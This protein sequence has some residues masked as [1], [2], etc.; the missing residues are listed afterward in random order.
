MQQASEKHATFSALCPASAPAQH[1][2]H[3]PART[4]S[5]VGT[6]DGGTTIVS[7]S[8]TGAGGYSAGHVSH[9]PGPV[10]MLP[11]PLHYSHHPQQPNSQL[12]RSS[13]MAQAC[14]D[15]ATPR[16]P[17]TAPALTASGAVTGGHP[18]TGHTL[19]PSS[20][21]YAGV[22]GRQSS[23]GL[24]S[25]TF[26]LP[27]LGSSTLGAQD[28]SG[29]SAAQ[30]SDGTATA[31]GC[32]L[33]TT[34][35]VGHDVG[36]GTLCFQMPTM[37]QLR[38]ASSM[39]VADSGC[40]AQ[41][42]W[43]GILYAAAAP[44]AAQ[45]GINGPSP[46]QRQEAAVRGAT[47]SRGVSGSGM[48]E[49]AGNALSPSAH[50]H[51]T[52]PVSSQP[53]SRRSSGVSR[54]ELGAE[55]QP[56]YCALTA[57]STIVSGHHDVGPAGAGG[58]GVQA[59]SVHRVQGPLGLPPAFPSK[60]S[61]AHLLAPGSYSLGKPAV[62]FR[63]APHAYTPRIKDEPSDQTF[64]QGSTLQVRTSS[65]DVGAFLQQR[66]SVA[67]PLMATAP[68][69]SADKECPAHAPGFTP[70]GQ[71]GAMPSHYAAPASHHQ[72]VMASV[73][74]HMES[75]V[76]WAAGKGHHSTEEVQVGHRQS[77][78]AGIFSARTSGRSQGGSLPGGGIASLRVRTSSAG[79]APVPAQY[80]S[81][82]DL[83]DLSQLLSTGGRDS[84]DPL[85]LLLPSLHIPSGLPQQPVPQDSNGLAEEN[86][87]GTDSASD[88]GMF[89]AGIFA[90]DC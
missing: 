13:S 59:G 52:S 7:A 23:S 60:A 88:R 77:S 82:G 39:A 80:H 50:V 44:G 54:Q 19:S 49:Q 16:Y 20:D 42:R 28:A 11:Q 21:Q 68:L 15:V 22:M 48:Q 30:L 78:D 75:Q 26:T 71:L 85:L 86:T 79:G 74:G 37:G 65:M 18:A 34:K 33:A 84:P 64:T 2:H 27:R 51:C 89:E 45:V 70:S 6:V 29:C 36:Q 67:G 12:I 31:L 41:A 3:E 46:A 1:P 62:A 47:F 10:Q 14:S 90:D 66:T 81:G 53:L 56:G 87:A 38:S 17:A 55:Q 9:Q 83:G 73:V 69:H 63:D 8:N 72:Q 4:S 40:Q 58:A 24:H 25:S 5:G 35:G 76:H 57:G 32:G 61:R 43:P